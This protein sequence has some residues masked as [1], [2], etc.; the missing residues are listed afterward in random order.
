L[1]HRQHPAK[2]RSVRKGIC[3]SGFLALGCAFDSMQPG[4][5]NRTE[6]LSRD[7]LDLFG[8]QPPDAPKI[9]FLYF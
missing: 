6:A 1:A 8:I 9:I 3:I 2:D 7:F 5:L 4:A